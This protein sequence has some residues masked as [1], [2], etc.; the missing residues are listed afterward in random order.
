MKVSP[1]ISSLKVYKTGIPIEQI[2]RKYGLEKV[3]K[4]DSNENPLGPSPLVIEALQK[5]LSNLNFY[6]DASA[7]ALKQKMSEYWQVPTQWLS[8]GNGSSELIDLLVR[9]YC[10]PGDAILVSQVS[11]VAYKVCAQAA[12]VQIQDVPIREDMSIDAKG[13]VEHYQGLEKKG[14]QTPRLIFISNPN[15][16][17]GT[18]A[19]KKEID[20]LIQELGGRDDV[21]IVF[22]EAYNEFV[23]AK[24][25][26]N[27][28]DYLRE[29][30][31]IV[32]L[33]TMSKV[34]GLA[35]LRL[36]AVIARPEVI[37]LFDRVRSPFNVNTLAQVGAMAAVGDKNHLEKTCQTVWQ[38]LDFLCQELS[39][40]HLPYIPSQANFIFFD[41]LQK[42]S[43]LIG[44]LQSKGIL[45]RPMSGYGFPNHLRIT[46][47]TMEE[48]EAAIKA[49]KQILKR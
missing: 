40:L 6:P 31:N 32:V 27:T 12:R 45:L 41:A 20:F 43:D 16:P 49:L 21:L 29:H 22:D 4:L 7:E 38:G 36:G 5:A 13:L 44:K 11:F 17:T 14:Q 37:G 18:H 24:D 8:F 46:A 3:Y 23:R 10:E 26:P 30:K 47:G 34:F 9:I 15:N 39:A 28:F 19:T 1:S 42:N 25:Y 48:N 35:G 2:Q 33:R